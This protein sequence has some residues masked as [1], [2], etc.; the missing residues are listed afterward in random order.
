MN[1]DEIAEVMALGYANAVAKVLLVQA[2]RYI[3]KLSAELPNSSKAVEDGVATL[4]ST[5]D[6]ILDNRHH[7]LPDFGE[8]LPDLSEKVRPHLHVYLTE[9]WDT[10]VA[11]AA[12]GSNDPALDNV[13]LMELLD[14]LNG[15]P[16]AHDD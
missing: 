2:V 9:I 13:E 8:G 10:I 5:L 11:A 16:L 15:K 14:R 4:L 1:E 6:R 12:T 7:P 3:K